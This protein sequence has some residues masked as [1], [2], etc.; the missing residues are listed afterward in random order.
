[1][2]VATM[3]SQD[4]RSSWA[5]TSRHLIASKGHLPSPLPNEAL[6]ALQQM[7]EFLNHNELELA[8]EEAEF[9]GNL[10]HSPPA[11]WAELRRAAENMG[12]SEASSRYAARL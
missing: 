11:F 2:E 9:L 3:A 6:D 1:M 7:D 12:L 4:L 5:T 10:C 8:L